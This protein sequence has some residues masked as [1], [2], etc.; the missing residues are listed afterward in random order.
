MPI[1]VNFKLKNKEELARFCRALSTV[2]RLEILE[3]ISKKHCNIYEISNEL[4]ISY[5]TALR[6]V[7]QLYDAGLIFI[8]EQ[9]TEK[10]TISKNCSIRMEHILISI[11][12][13]YEAKDS[14]V[15]VLSQ[16]IGMY[17]NCDIMLPC[18]LWSKDGQIYRTDDIQSFWHPDRIKAQLL[19]F[20]AGNVEYQFMKPF[21]SVGEINA[22]EISFESC[23]EAPNYRMDWKSDITVWL[24]DSEIGT[25]TS[26]SDFGGRRGQF[27]PVWWPLYSTQYGML[28]TFRVDGQGCYL[29]EVKI[30][31]KK[32]SDIRF[33]KNFIKL[34]IGIK[35]EAL[36]Q[37]GINLFGKEF[38]DYSQD[39]VMKI[40]HNKS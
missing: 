12:D 20:S 14:R 9:K 25:W 28:K 7:N 13:E 36:N 29:D 18:G 40:F 11:F 32:L 34:N 10:N 17:S 23:S 2:E 3:L 15:T 4:H 19:C 5:P 26:P 38:G 33:D 35:K 37:G 39:I 6:L 8:T 31:N 22:I 21:Q 30:S 27:T 16:G 24:N 1:D